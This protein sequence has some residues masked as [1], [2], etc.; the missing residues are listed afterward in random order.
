VIYC[1]DRITDTYSR[2]GK[3]L[4]GVATTSYVKA[5]ENGTRLI[6][7][8]GE[9]LHG[10]KGNSETAVQIATVHRRASP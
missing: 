3:L 1:Y 6:S 10:F 2:V 5:D 8:G 9:A 4:Y 7:F